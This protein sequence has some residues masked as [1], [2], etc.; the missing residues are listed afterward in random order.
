MYKLDSGPVRGSA[1]SEV[2]K[3]QE[4]PAPPPDTGKTELSLLS[5][6]K[7]PGT[8]EQ[9]EEI[10]PAHSS[11]Y[12]AALLVLDELDS[13]A[14]KNTGARAITMLLKRLNTTREATAEKFAA[15]IEMPGKQEDIEKIMYTAVGL[16]RGVIP[17]GTPQQSEVKD[18]ARRM[19]AEA[20]RSG[21]TLRQIT[22]NSVTNLTGLSESS[23]VNEYKGL[24]E[25][26][27]APKASDVFGYA[28]GGFIEGAKDIGSRVGIFLL[29]SVITQNLPGFVKDRMRIEYDSPPDQ[30]RATW[31]TSTVVAGLANGLIGAYL[32]ART[33][34]PSPTPHDPVGAGAIAGMLC[35]VTLVGWG[36]ELAL[37][38]PLKLVCPGEDH[39]RY[40][41]IMGGF[42]GWSLLEIACLPV[43]VAIAAGAALMDKAAHLTERVREQKASRLK[44]SGF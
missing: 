15:D 35:V 17:E 36:L 44:D 23:V 42:P 34:P 43:R 21:L 27:S 12:L 14:V 22:I 26:I 18:A 38:A 7:R 41:Y 6:P 11:R 40:S 33:L 30:D 19:I 8:A 16:K 39:N 2:Q 1:Q 10:S 20:R 25:K 29:R 28:F 32:L 37:R 5:F 24:F 31:W 9:A 3:E 13:L 4:F